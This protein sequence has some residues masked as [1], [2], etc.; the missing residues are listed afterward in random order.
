M[1][2]HQD[3]AIRCFLQHRRG[4]L[5][6]ATGSGK[7]RTAIRIMEELLKSGEISQILVVVYGNDLLE[8]WYREL[9]LCMK[10]LRIY[11]WF[12]NYNE[13]LRF[14]LFEGKK[15]LLVSREGSRLTTVL[16]KMERNDPAGDVKKRTF[17][18]YDEVHEAGSKQFREMLKGRLTEYR[19]CL[20]LS[21]TPVRTFD[22][23]GTEFITTEIGPVIYSYGLQEA[24]QAGILCSFSY[25]PIPYE[26]TGEEKQKKKKLI[27]AF[28]AR[29]KNGD[30]VAEEE[31]YRELAR[32]N[33]LA[34][35]KLVLF[36][37]YLERHPEILDHCIM[38]VETREYGAKLQRILMDHTYRFHTYYAEDDR[39]N[40]LRFARGEIRCLI[41]C[42]KISEGIDIRSVKNIV[43]FSSDRGHLVTTQ[44]IGRSLRRNPDDPDKIACVVDFICESGNDTTADEER[45]EW[46]S[47]LAK[48]RRR[49][50]E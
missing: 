25:I 9:M 7:T 19:F 18:V 38:F 1:W 12:G 44:R 32:V 48:V 26:L 10:D 6:M 46:L 29:K 14:L 34:E 24:I 27:A 50:S 45:K 5:E 21:A 17:F 23:E 43:L 42:R 41:T 11:R 20:G 39:K 37:D 3:E 2:Q 33:K 40:L 36:R 35:N 4:I 47:D 49:D 16:D 15:L 22:P 28:E 31:L 13:V 8:Q 30:P